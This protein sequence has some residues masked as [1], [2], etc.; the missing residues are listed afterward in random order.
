[1]TAVA[2]RATAKTLRSV[3]P[4]SSKREVSIHVD[5]AA[6][7]VVCDEAVIGRVLTNLIGNAV[8]FTGDGGTIRVTVARD[9]SGT[10]FSVTDN[11]S[12][13]APEF[14]ERVFDRFTQ[15]E[16]TPASTGLGLTFCK[17]A[18]EAHGGRIGVQSAVGKGSTFWFVLPA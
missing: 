5:P 18:V 1:M 15:V 14:H 13:I 4:E 10:L 6:A 8:K 2:A 9:G 16:R 11:G 17:L 3:G 7:S 12:G